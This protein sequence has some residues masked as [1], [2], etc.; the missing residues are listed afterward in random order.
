MPTFVYMTS[1]DGCGRSAGQGA[2][3]ILGL[4]RNRLQAN[5]VLR[6]APQM[7]AAVTQAEV[8]ALLFC[9]RSPDHQ[10]LCCDR[11]AGPPSP[12]DPSARMLTEGPWDR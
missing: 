8:I 4:G 2:R 7:A 5:T 3:M 11:F 1:C 10:R 9:S 12:L 6:A